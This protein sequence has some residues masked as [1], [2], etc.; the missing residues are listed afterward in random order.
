MGQAGEKVGAAP[1]PYPHQRVVNARLQR[2]LVHAWQ[3]FANSISINLKVD[4][5]QV[6]HGLKFRACAHNACRHTM[7]DVPAP[8]I[9]ANPACRNNGTSNALGRGPD[10]GDVE[11]FTLWQPSASRTSPRQTQFFLQ[12]EVGKACHRM[13]PA[14]QCNLGSSHCAVLHKVCVCGG[15]NKPIGGTCKTGGKKLASARRERRPFASSTQEQCPLSGRKAGMCICTFCSRLKFASAFNCSS[16]FHQPETGLAIGLPL[17]NNGD[18]AHV[19][20]YSRRQG[21]VN[22]PTKRPENNS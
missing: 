5:K 17:P 18:G 7:Q 13:Y 4:A 11:G 14:D 2:A 19:Y 15:G 21:A 6:H 8:A 10:Y 3:A 1:R 22:P 12:R 20:G 16:T 9:S